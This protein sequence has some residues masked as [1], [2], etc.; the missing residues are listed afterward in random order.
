MSRRASF[1][2]EAASELREA[3]LW[4]EARRSGLGLAFLAAVESAIQTIVAWPDTGALVSPA[5]DDL[6]LRRV[7]VDRFPYHVGYVA[8]DDEILVLA[9]AHDRRRP[10]YWTSRR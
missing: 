9:V 6:V 5:I 3:A 10:G 8:C 1:Q 2:P 7:R 4:Y